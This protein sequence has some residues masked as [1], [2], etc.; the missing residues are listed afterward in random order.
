MPCLSTTLSQGVIPH[1]NFFGKAKKSTWEA[2]KSY[3][4]I[5]HVFQAVRINPYKKLMATSPEFVDLEQFTCVIYN[6]T[7]SISQ[8]NDLRQEL[9][10]RKP[11]LIETIPPTQVYSLIIPSIVLHER[12][13]LLLCILQAALLEHSNRA[14][15]QASVWLTSLHSLQNLPSPEGY[16]WTMKSNIWTPFWTTLPEIAKASQELLKCGCKAVPLCSRRCKC[17][18]AGLSC[19]TLCYCRGSCEN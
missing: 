16:G 2:W 18:D 6:K 19:T 11:R 3:P 13:M 7:T 5:T 9:F 1:H 15:Y 10:S 4:S 14:P 12:I 8:V 17:K